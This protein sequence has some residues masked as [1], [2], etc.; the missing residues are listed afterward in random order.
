MSKSIIPSEF[1]T[2]EIKGQAKLSESQLNSIQST[3]PN[4][5]TGAIYFIPAQVSFIK[6]VDVNGRQVNS[7]RVAALEIINN[8]PTKVVTIGVSALRASYVGLVSEGKPELKMELRTEG[9]ASGLY[10]PVAGQGMRVTT[11]DNP[12]PLE[13]IERNDAKTVKI[14]TP[15]AITVKGRNAY[16]QPKFVEQPDGRYDMAVDDNMNA[17][18]RIINDYVLKSV[19]ATPYAVHDLKTLEPRVADYLL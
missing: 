13:V 8:K 12:A 2:F 6:T 18:L 4:L 17:T 16:W 3:T 14:A 10:R 7:N 9:A 5:K 19:D 15:F 11:L 1:S